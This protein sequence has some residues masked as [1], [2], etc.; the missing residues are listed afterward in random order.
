MNA[1]LKASHYETITAPGA[2]TMYEALCELCAARE[3]DMT[4][5]DQMLIADIARCEQ[6]KLK[7]D[8][9][10]RL[11]GVGSERFNGRQKYYQENKAVPMLLAYTE[12][13]QKNMADLRLK[14][15]A[16][17]AKPEDPAEDDGWNDIPD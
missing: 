10:I 3:G 11:H 8:E 2:R 7:L 12:Q 9:D 15:K 14:P 6:V 17:E 5:V 1:D 13:Q 4:D 16:S